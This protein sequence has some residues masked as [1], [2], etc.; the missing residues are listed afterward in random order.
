MSLAR[1]RQRPGVRQAAHFFTGAPGEV[2]SNRVPLS[3]ISWLGC[4]VLSSAP[5]VGCSHEPSAAQLKLSNHSESAPAPS[6][7]TSSVGPPAALVP[8]SARVVADAGAEPDAA[9]KAAGR[10]VDPPAPAPT[11]SPETGNSAGP[12]AALQDEQGK[13]LPQ[14][15][16]RPSAT[17]AAFEERIAL[18]GKAILSGDPEPASAAFFPLVAY[19]QVKDVAK[20]ERDY[21]FRL[22]ANFKRDIMEYH[23]ALGARASEAKFSG[24]TVSE[25]DAKWMAPGSEGNKLGYFRVLRSRLHFTLPAGRTRDFELTSLISWRGEWYVVHLHGFK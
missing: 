15:E 10:A 17:S 12:S 1:A 4:L 2:Y 7:S 3:R 11:S 8:A 20:P 14:T 21:R 16:Q 9:L 19:Q 5:L 23:R 6:T 18:V 24:I 25:R 13:P 22:L